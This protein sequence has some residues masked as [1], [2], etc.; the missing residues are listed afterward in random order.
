MRLAVKDCIDVAGLP[1]T[2]GC[3]EVAERARP[4]VRDAAVV[5]AARRSGAKIVGKTNLSE[6]CWSAA[7][8]NA[9]SGTPV[10]P[11]DPRRLPGGSS[12]GSAVAVACGE[13]DVALGTDGG[14]SVRLP[15]ACC[16]IVGLKTTWGRLPVEG[17]YP[18]APS[19]DTVGLLGAEVAAAELGMRLIEPGFAAGPGELRMARVR[20]QTEPEV[21]PAVEA[22]IDAALRAAGI[23]TTEVAGLDFGAAIAAGTLLIDAEAYQASKPLMLDP[24]RLSPHSRRILREAAAVSAGQVAAANRTRAAGTQVVR[25]HAGPPSVPGLADHGGRA[26][27]DRRRAAPAP[28][29][30]DH[31]G[32]PGRAARASP[33]RTRR[34]G[35]AARLVAAHRAARERG[36][37]DL[38][39]PRD[40]GR[41]P[42]TAGWPGLTNVPRNRSERPWPPDGMRRGMAAKVSRC[43]MPYDLPSDIERIVEAVQKAP[44]IL[45][46]RPWWFEFR[47]PDHVDLWLRGDP[48]QSLPPNTARARTREYVISCGAALFDLRMTIR[49]AGHDLVVWL[50]P[51]PKHAD[52][53]R[54][55]ALLASVEIVIGRVKKPSI[56]EQELY[57]AIGRRHTNRSPYVLPVPLPIIA[58]MEHAAAQEGAY[59]R[60]LHPREAK[61]WL[62]QTR[63]VDGN[64]AF[65]PP[66]TNFVSRENSGPLPANRQQSTRPNFW[67]KVTRHREKPQ[68]MALSTDDDEP[69][70]WLRA[71]QALQRAVLTGTWYSVSAPYGRAARYHAPPRYGVPARH[72]LLKHDEL[73]PYGLSASPLT[74]SLEWDD[75]HG[76]ARRWPWRW[77]YPDL[78]QMIVRVGYAAIPAK[79]DVP[80]VTQMGTKVSQPSRQPP[81]EALASP[82]SPQP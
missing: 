42:V 14:G 61:R 35:R 10:N 63:A 1:T 81:P 21:D 79:G 8:I 40:R 44:S 57:E 22:A 56:A 76:E 70:D 43:A 3:Q 47:P 19:M 20:P 55:P 50:L 65:T 15:A 82:D 52:P 26:A 6:L 16:G 28:H 29:R 36:T 64:P 73:A 31:A 30:A 7:G 54:P 2:L 32:Q 62:R 72:H 13:A 48:R 51:D 11:L 66:F 80:P 68:L 25:R 53:M 46:T 12:S 17:V 4:A 77:R 58:D 45:N 18:L 39:R 27:A 37:A 69:V 75:I 5:A 71:G 23:A 59:L 9:W 38:A 60:L 49:M 34:P 41:A 33:A 24:A 78:P 74:Q 67:L